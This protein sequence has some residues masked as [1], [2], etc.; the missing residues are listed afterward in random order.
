MACSTCGNKGKKN[1][2]PTV[3][4]NY[5]DIDYLKNKVPTVKIPYSEIKVVK[6]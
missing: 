1:P 4:V 5:A 6:K 2:I 3:K